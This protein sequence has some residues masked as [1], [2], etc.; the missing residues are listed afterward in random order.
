MKISSL[1]TFCCALLLFSCRKES[2]EK[3]DQKDIYTSYQVIYDADQDATYA[4][5]WFR[6][7]N[8]GG[9]FLKL[10]I[11]SEL[12]VN[13]GSLDYVGNYS[14]YEKKQ[15]GKFETHNFL[16]EDLDGGTYS[17]NLTLAD[18][19]SFPSSVDTIYQ[20]STTYIQWVG[21]PIAADEKVRLTVFDS[22]T[23]ATNISVLTI[24]SVGKNGVYIESNDFEYPNLLNPSTSNFFNRLKTGHV[25]V[26]FEREKKF[27]TNAPAAGGQAVSIYSSGRKV[28][29]LAK[30]D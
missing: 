30:K 16:Y 20:D 1:V 24:D 17:N 29:W 15:S 10:S 19:I 18:S 28:I 5:A 7:N 13:N 3:I 14:W 2:S 21:E 4:R 26:F 23:L 12:K 22:T 8:S 9:E 25:I 6:A 27:S 11:K